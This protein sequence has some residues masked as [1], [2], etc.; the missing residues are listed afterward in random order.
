[1]VASSADLCRGLA[2]DDLVELSRTARVGT[3]IDHV[4]VVE[5]DLVRRD[6]L[7][8]SGRVLAAEMSVQLST[9]K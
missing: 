8:P 6:P 4:A 7:G 1:M 2:H 3:W 9:A 5:L